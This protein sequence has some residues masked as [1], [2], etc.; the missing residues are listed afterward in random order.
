MIF[1]IYILYIWNIQ[2]IN[3]F[4][5]LFILSRYFQQYKKTN[6]IFFRLFWRTNYFHNK[7]K[8]KRFFPKKLMWLY[9]FFTKQKEKKSYF[10]SHCRPFLKLA[11]LVSRLFRHYMHY[12]TCCWGI[13]CI[14]LCNLLYNAGNFISE[15]GTF[16]W[17]ISRIDYVQMNVLTT[18]IVYNLH[19]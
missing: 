17:Q 10:C 7:K 5:K 9:I 15:S 1:K 8:L 4:K 13:T 2:S 3:I 11:I 6:K 16:M 12:I 14:L 19:E 18:Y